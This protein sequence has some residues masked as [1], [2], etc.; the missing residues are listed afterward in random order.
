MPIILPFF[1]QIRREKGSLVEP[2]HLATEYLTVFAWPFFAVM[3]LLAFPIVRTLFGDQWN[4]SVPVTQILCIGAAISSLGLFAGEVM[5]ANGHIRQVTK[6]Q[7]ITSATRVI[8]LLVGSAYGLV[9]IAVAVAVSEGIS[10]LVI[11]RLLYAT[12]GIRFMGVL[13]A[14]GKSAI[15]T[16]FSVIVPALT[17]M[18][19][20][21][22][23]SST[24]VPLVIGI[25]GAF[26]GWII[27]VVIT[28]HAMKSHIGRVY[29]LAMR[30]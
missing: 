30:Q 19:W 3:S 24:W 9:S 7:L 1:A 21:P 10:L 6:T 25:P 16:I 23:N 15:V 28:G 2:Y 29:K 22:N 17:I 5:V 11:S 20:S 26:A 18:V 8:A 12:T 27:G 4:A 14:T 13:R